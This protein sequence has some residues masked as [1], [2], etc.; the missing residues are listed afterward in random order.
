M[1]AH[2]C[3]LLTNTST[4]PAVER[5][6][7]THFSVSLCFPV[8][9][10]YLFFTF[11]AVAAGKRGTKSHS[12]TMCEVPILFNFFVHVAAVWSGRGCTSSPLH[13]QTDWRKCKRVLYRRLERT[14]RQEVALN[15]MSSNTAMSSYFPKIDTK[16]THILLSVRR[17]I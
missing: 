2:T 4:N 13:T 11:R 8:L 10:T 16:F 5:L 15:S 17:C 14:K 6:Q 7:N 3:G 9:P 12:I 1:I